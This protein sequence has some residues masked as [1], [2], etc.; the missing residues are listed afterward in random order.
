M[1]SWSAPAREVLLQDGA[2][3]T[4]AC[5]SCFWKPGRASYRGRISNCTYPT[6]S[7]ILSQSVPVAKPN[8]ASV[9]S[10]RS[11]R[12]NANCAHGTRFLARWSRV[13]PVSHPALVTGMCLAWE[14]ALSPSLANRIACTR[15]Q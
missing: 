5:R 4:K 13:L 3:V 12:K 9:L 10:A 2:C 15:R 1:L 11:I 14:A 6:G 7:V 8:S